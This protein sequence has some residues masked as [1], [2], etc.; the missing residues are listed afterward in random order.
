[1]KEKTKAWVNSMGLGFLL[2]CTMMFMLTF[3]VA[4]ST[5]TN[6]V[7]VSIDDYGEANLEFI[8]LIL[9]IPLILIGTYNILMQQRKIIHET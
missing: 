7:Y 8:I 9:S 6:S 1:M 4:Y 2:A 3:F 5:E